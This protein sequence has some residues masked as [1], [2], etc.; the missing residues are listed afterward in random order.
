LVAYQTV[1]IDHKVLLKLPALHSE[2]NTIDFFVK[3]A[4]IHVEI[5][6]NDLLV[7]QLYASFALLIVDEKQV[8][9]C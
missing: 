7:P 2:V 1:S 6:V 9:D 8:L 4:V 3:L 5:V